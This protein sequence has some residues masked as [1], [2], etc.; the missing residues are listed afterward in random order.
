MNEPTN[1]ENF[2]CPKN[3]LEDPPYKPLAVRQFD[4]GTSKKRMSDKTICMIALQEELDTVY[5]H[6]DVHSLYGLN[7]NKPTL[8]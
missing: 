8:E 5:N 2:S 7:Q 4:Q 6:Y 1:F 3:I